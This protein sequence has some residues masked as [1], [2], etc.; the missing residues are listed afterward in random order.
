[1]TYLARLSAL[2][3]IASN[4]RVTTEERTGKDVEGIGHTLHFNFE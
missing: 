1:M 4:G 3:Y 2:K